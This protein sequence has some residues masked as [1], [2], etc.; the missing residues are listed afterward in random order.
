[1]LQGIARGALKSHGVLID[2]ALGQDVLA[3]EIIVGEAAA[4]VVIM[5]GGFALRPRAR[6][7]I[8]K[9]RP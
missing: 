5:P 9:R 4:Q 8:S 3:E 6:L 1:M 7:G 2:A